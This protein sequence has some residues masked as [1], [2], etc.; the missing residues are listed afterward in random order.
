P[1]RE[2]PLSDAQSRGGPTAPL[3]P[4]GG[5]SARLL[6][7]SSGRDRGID[8]LARRT[9][10]ARLGWGERPEHHALDERQMARER[11]SHG[12]RT[13]GGEDREGVAPVGGIDLAS[14]PA[15]GLQSGP[16]PARA[17]GRGG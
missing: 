2:G 17:G 1:A 15:R 14:A 3:L 5:P 8:P 11:L 10:G 16:G 12:R 6:P 4:A 7:A 9:E 13:G